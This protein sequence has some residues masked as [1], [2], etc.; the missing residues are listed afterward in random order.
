M[1]I[2]VIDIGTN[3]I[4][5]L[6]GHMNNDRLVRIASDRAVTRLGK[7]LIRTGLLSDDSINKSLNAL[8]LFKAICDKHN[9]KKIVAV[10]TSALREATNSRDFISTVKN[11]TG[12]EIEIISGEKEAALTVKGVTAGIGDKKKPDTFF[13]IDIGGGSTEWIIYKD[14]IQ[15][16][17]TRSQEKTK[18]TELNSSL[19]THA[20][21][22]VGKVPALSRALSSPTI[23][24]SSLLLGSVPVG[25][26]KLFE[27]FIKHD[28][29]TPE[30]LDECRELI[31]LKLSESIDSSLMLPGL[32]LATN[33]SALSLIATGGTPTTIGA[34]DL[35][36]NKYDGDR[37]HMHNISA[38]TL[39]GIFNKLVSLP[40][41]ERSK[42]KGMGPERSDI[43]IPGSLILMTIM[44][45]LKIKEAI[46][47]DYGLL[48]GLL[49]Y[50]LS[51]EKGF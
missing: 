34:I 37:I 21:A 44:E 23:G 36:L 25:A 8:R 33:H 43:I 30:E 11:E 28:P 46:I 47:S 31:H 41:E 32:L 51:N 5:L 24:N 4:R 3:T 29:P 27:M 7:D 49:C 2:A 45:Y 17:G 15:E 16:S 19:K 39:T 12:V 42:V 6:I 20:S 1:N 13:I 50:N 14:S 10:G 48:E 22:K 18:N 35:G 40:H 38:N 9:V 26:V